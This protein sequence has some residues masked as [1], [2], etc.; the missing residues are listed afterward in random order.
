MGRLL[1]NLF[2][3]LQLAV[4]KGASLF[5]NKAAQWVAGRSNWRERLRQALSPG[6]SWIWVHAA[7]LGEFEQG[8]P[9]IERLQKDYPG[10]KILLSFFSPSGYAIQKDY[11]GAAHVCYLPADTPG[12][13]RDFLAIVQPRAVF[14]IKY[15]FWYHYLRQLDQLKIPVFLVS[16]A[17]L[18]EH[19][20][21]QWY[22]G[23]FRKLLRYYTLIFVQDPAN[24]ALLA[25]IGLEK[26]V[27]VAGDTRYDRVA[28]IAGRPHHNPVVEHFGA[29]HRLFIAGSTWPKDEVLLKRFLDRLPP[30]WKLIIAPHDIAESHLREISVL[31]GD[32]AVFYTHY[33]LSPAASDRRVLVIDN[34]G[35]LSQLYA[36]G[37]LAYVG[38]GFMKRGLHNILEP[39]VFGLPVF[40][41][42]EYSNFVEAMQF[43]QK[44]FAFPITTDAE[45]SS[46]FFRF[47]HD[48]QRYLE[49][50]GQIRAFMQQNIGATERVVTAIRNQH[51]IA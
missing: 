49:L 11:P 47:Q 2:I 43:V 38:G 36:Y 9:L 4:F 42:P 28:D 39:A 31:F 41:G 27:L 13:A 10:H 32:T 17:F 45:L 18:R 44:G 1:Y 26:N 25:G 35:L 46:L 8:R 37:T 6:T 34:I 16:A 29:N 14:F 22:G 50:S 24:Q 3:Y 30:D 23:F 40:F 20:F 12:N 33:E 15:E 5:H 21:F 51:P 19:V 48:P 7:S